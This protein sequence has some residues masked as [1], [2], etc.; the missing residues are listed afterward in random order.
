MYTW[1]EFN[2]KLD[3]SF[4]TQETNNVDH[5]KYTFKFSVLSL[6]K[7]GKTIYIQYNFL[8]CKNLRIHE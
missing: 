2:N 5:T 3:K 7:V 6:F 4:S 1:T 8:S